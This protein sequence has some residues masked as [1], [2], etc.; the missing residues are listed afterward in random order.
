MERHLDQD[1]DRVR[2]M[3]LKMGGNGEAVHQNGGGP[4]DT[5]SGVQTPAPA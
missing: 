3:L 4:A 1:L 2:Q 5:G